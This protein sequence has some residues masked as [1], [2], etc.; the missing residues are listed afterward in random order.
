MKAMVYEGAWQMPLREVQAPTPNGDD[1]VV[2]VKAVGI[3]GSDVHGFKGATGRRKPP[4][5]MGHE[6]SGT[7]AAVGKHVTEFKVGDRV[8]AQPLLPC[9]YCDNCRAGLTNMCSNRS[10]LGMNL[11]GA[12]A[13]AVR[14]PRELLYRLPDNMSYEQGAMVEP[15]A[16]GM[17]AVNLTPIQLMDT[18]VIIGAGTIGLLTLLAAKLRGAGKVIM[19]DISPHRLDMAMKLGADVVV[20]VSKQDPVSIAKSQTDGVG[21]AAVIEAVGATPT[22]QQSLLVVRD[23]GHVTWIGNSAP[24]V[25]V[26][27]QQVVTRELKVAGAYGSNV[28]FGQAIKAIEAGRI[29]VTPLIELTAPLDKGPDLITDL[30][31]GTLDAV[32]V[33]LEP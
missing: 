26:P 13:E 33:M 22:V 4:I 11:D 29:Q 10:G 7:I 19:T 31:K 6:F 9:G 16:V 20:D 2:N 21:A 3:C 18:L 24:M 27:M 30:A 28:E 17:H 5:I 14:V 15:L 32:K 1:V 25:E 12:Y 23:G 8:V